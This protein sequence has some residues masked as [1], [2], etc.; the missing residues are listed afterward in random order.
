[1]ARTLSEG[2]IYGRERTGKEPLKGIEK[3]VL[4]QSDFPAEENQPGPSHAGSFVPSEHLPLPLYSRR[5]LCRGTAKRRLQKWGLR[6]GE[7]TLPL[8]IAELEPKRLVCCLLELMG[9]KQL[10]LPIS[11]V[12][13]EGNVP[14]SPKALGYRAFSAFQG[15][16][17]A[18][19]LH[20]HSRAR[21][22]VFRLHKAS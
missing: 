2:S 7:M 6:H 1:M 22:Y 15:R 19:F 14:I 13:L 18:T 4:P 16:S 12:Y 10:S 3:A 9:P 21:F 8:G 11:E 20:P 17:S 5:C